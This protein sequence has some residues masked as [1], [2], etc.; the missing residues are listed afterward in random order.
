M[1][2][3][4]TQTDEGQLVNRAVSCFLLHFTSLPMIF[5]RGV[6]LVPRSRCACPC[7]VW[8]VPCVRVPRSSVLSSKLHT[9]CSKLHTCCL[10][11][12]H[13]EPELTAS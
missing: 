2:A 1:E 8:G 11:S 5:G 9:V 3:R 10:T 7:A 12:L 4:G 6:S 13:A